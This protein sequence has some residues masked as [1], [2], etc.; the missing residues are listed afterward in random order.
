MKPLRKGTFCCFKLFG[1]FLNGL[2]QMKYNEK[3]MQNSDIGSAFKI[4]FI[5]STLRM[6]IQLRLFDS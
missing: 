2:P 5:S 6:R 3:G 4:S 1:L